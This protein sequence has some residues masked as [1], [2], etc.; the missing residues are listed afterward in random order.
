MEQAKERKK[1]QIRAW[2]SSHSPLTEERSGIISFPFFIIVHAYRLDLY[3]SYLPIWPWIRGEVFVLP[4]DIIGRD[5]E[6]VNSESI[7]NEC[8]V[9]NEAMDLW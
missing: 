1:G 3:G 8:D 6:E 5:N 2:G 7:M 9:S 4:T